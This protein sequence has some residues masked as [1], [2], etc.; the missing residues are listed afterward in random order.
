M[1][2]G[3]FERTEEYRRIQSIAQKGNQNA[4]GYKHTKEECEKISKAKK[5]K[6]FTRE[7][8][9]NMSKGQKKRYESEEEKEKRRKFMH[10][11]YN[12]RNGDKNRERQR[13]ITMRTLPCHYNT[14]SC[15]FFRKFDKYLNTEGLYGRNEHIVSYLGYRLDYINFD[16]KLIVEWDEERYHYEKNLLVK[17]DIKRQREIEKHYSDFTFYRIREK[18]YKDF[19][20]EINNFVEWLEKQEEIKIAS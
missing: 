9:A 18:D 17:K 7:H 15:K 5:G 14:K 16:L 20:T 10:E 19:E 3:V 4:L 8:I 12:G 2:S 1:P 6:K 11:H 13:I